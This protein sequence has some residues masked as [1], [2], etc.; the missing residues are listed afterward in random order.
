MNAG[1]AVYGI[2]S[3]NTEVTDIVSTRI[4]PEIAEQEAPVPFIVYQV[5]NVSP[6]DTHDGPST[7]DEIRFEFLCYDATY[8][9]AAELGDKV[10]GALDRVQGT[11]NTVNVQS[12]QFNDVDTEIIDE[13]RRYAQVLTFTFR[14]ARDNFT[15]A[16]GT[17]VT[18]AMLGDL[19]DVNTTGVTDGQV[20]AY[21]AA[22]AVW[23]PATDAGGAEQL[24]DLSDVIISQ[25]A[26]GEFF[27]YD[28]GEWVNDTA[29]KSDVGL[30]NVDNTSDAN[31]PISTATQT[32][33]DLKADITSVP[34]E[35]DDL[36]DVQIIGTPTLGQALVYGAGKW[37]PG[38]AGATDLGDLDDV[39]TT[40]AAFGSLLTYNGAS[41]DISGSQLPTDDIY[42][43]QR[44]ETESEAL[45]TGATATTELYFTCTAQGNGLAESAS[46]DTP[47]AGKIIRRKIYYSEAGFA[48]P[49]TGTWVEFTPAPAD[50]AAF[51]TVKAALLEYLK[52]R[53]G[54]TVPISLKQTWEEVT[55]APA[56]TGLLNET[57]GSGAEA[58]YSTRRLNGNVTDCMVIRRASDSTTTTIGFDSEGNISEADIISFCTGTTCTVYQW[59]DQSGNGN[60][61]TA[62]STGAEPT[63]YTGGALVKENGK[64]AV[65]FDADYLEHSLSTSGGYS[66][67]HLLIGLTSVNTPNNY[68]ITFCVGNNADNVNGI[69]LMTAAST[70]PSNWGTFQGGSKKSTVSMS[71]GFRRLITMSRGAS[72]N[73][74]FYTDGTTSGTYN[75]TSG[76]TYASLGHPTIK[77]NIQEVIFYASD[78]STSDRTS[79]E[80][81][82]GDYF[83]QNTPLLDTYTGAAAAYSL[84]L[85]DSTYT[86]SAIRVRRSS[87][88]TE[89]DIGFNI[90]GELDTVSLL[91]FAGTGDAFVKVW[92]DQA[93]TNDATQTDTAKQPQIVSSGAVI[94]LGNKPA[95]TG[96]SS[97]SVLSIATTI[98][99]SD[100]GLMHVYEEKSN[101]KMTWGLDSSKY[102][103]HSGASHRIN[104][105]INFTSGLTDGDYVLDFANR[106]SGAVEV[107]LNGA[108]V[109]TATNTGGYSFK[110]L[111]NAHSLGFGYTAPMQEFVLW[112][113]EQS[114]NRTGIET[115]INTF[116]SIY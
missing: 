4:Y 18:G 71:D 2:L 24:N 44:Y 96:V 106:N 48:D 40:G 66:T 6:E 59:L 35:L 89:Q 109:S 114:A 113:S 69:V 20:I 94:V 102:Y 38:A 90:F 58:A 31:K 91:A 46:S 65:D 42:F 55:A 25:P 108:S 82:V 63:I 105:M 39:N 52:A 21:D 83:T 13:P 33:L 116:Y 87:D 84:R 88:N 11:Y 34:T 86:G 115:N 23:L 27:R 104:D 98:N 107:D 22:T 36:N 16:Q 54:G 50:D 85:L 79:I 70:I 61:A 14:I 76:S 110:H 62:P 57:Y 51:A 47:T 26:Q 29:S 92:Y 37:L 81:N 49:D 93:S 72:G 53:T 68:S 15:I 95:I 43:H 32:A 5:Q 103:Y 111:F 80:S 97:S 74:N 73:G 3:T 100:F 8:N 9:G 112:T 7:L 75:G 67:S 10:R 1:K 28:G 56:F 41:W 12:V 60:D 17:P 30:G 77:D 45:R 101:N 64:V 99:F 19:Y 78:K